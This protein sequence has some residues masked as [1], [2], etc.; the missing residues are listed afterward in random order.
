VWLAALAGRLAF[1][2]HRARGHVATWKTWSQD[3]SGCPGDIVCHDCGQVLWC[4]AHDP[5]R[6]A[7]DEAAPDHWGGTGAHH[8]SGTLLD[9]LEHVLRLAEACP[10]GP[11]GDTLRRAACELIEADSSTRR[12]ACRRRMLKFVV[13]LQERSRR[14]SHN[15]DPSPLMLKQLMAVLRR[16]VW[17]G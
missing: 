7:T 3:P 8:P 10:C 4:R 9:R 5:W 16:D 12:T 2:A 14:G 6:I 13:R 11:S 1:L 15:D 17:A